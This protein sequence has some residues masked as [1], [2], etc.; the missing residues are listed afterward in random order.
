MRDLPIACSLDAD[1]LA[2]R[3]GE[4]R[5]LGRDALIAVDP[6]GVLRFR[7]TPSTRE[8]LERIVAA[9]AECCPFL[10][11]ELSQERDELHLTVSAPNEAEPVAME[12]VEWFA[13]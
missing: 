6:G 10:G 13:G 3:V 9:E 5:A 12:L 2:E 1:A 7:A 11:L 8:R 4:I